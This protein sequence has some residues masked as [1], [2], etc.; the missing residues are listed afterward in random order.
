VRTLK[1][2][3]YRIA[4]NAAL[5]TVR[6][7]PLAL[8]DLDERLESA[9]RTETAAERH[10]GLRDVVSAMQA[11]PLRQR[12]AIVQRELEG[13]SYE[14]IAVALGVSNGAVRQL[15]NRART[16]LR[17]GAAAIAAPFVP[18]AAGLGASGGGVAAKACATA[19]VTGVLATGV[20][21]STEDAISVP[22]RQK[23][24]RPAAKAPAKQLVAAVAPAQPVRQATAAAAPPT[25]PT[26]VRREPARP[27]ERDRKREPV[28]EGDR[29]RPP[30]EHRGQHH[31]ND[32]RDLPD[33][34]QTHRRDA[35]EG[36]LTFPEDPSYAPPTEPGDGPREPPPPTKGHR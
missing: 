5:N 36:S 18:L 14:E 26:P 1:P 24:E 22:E 16:S 3:L 10:E 13:R 7:K 30:R 31:T 29:D 12:D 28:D 17:A 2:W 34:A 19:C 33:G 35:D 25:S 21:P 8:V 9:E 23:A 15:L 32:I 27:R 6:A 4:H 11:L 20:A